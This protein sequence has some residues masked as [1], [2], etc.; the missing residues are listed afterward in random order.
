MFASPARALAGGGTRLR[1]RAAHGSGAAADT[2][3]APSCL[4]LLLLGC[5][6]RVHGEGEAERR[7]HTW[8]MDEQRCASLHVG[9][10]TRTGRRAWG[11]VHPLRNAVSGSTQRSERCFYRT[12]RRT[13]VASAGW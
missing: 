13:S 10:M 11:V 7:G 2:V 12:S 6:E 3:A 9:W 8:A 5:W 4:L 1:P